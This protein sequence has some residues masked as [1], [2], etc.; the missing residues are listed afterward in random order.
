[1][2]GSIYEDLNEQQAAAVAH[3]EGPLM[4]LAGAGSGKTRVVTRR[5]ARLMMDGVRAH[6]ILALTFTNKAAGEMARRVEQ[7]GGDYVRVATFHSACA[8]FLRSEA[9]LIGYAPDY[10]IYDTQ[11]RDSLIKELMAEHHISTKEAKPSLIGN[12]ISK[13]KNA[14]MTPDD[15]LLGSSD[16]MR[17][18]ERL[19]SP[20]QERMKKASA[21]DFD[22]LLLNF[23]QILREHPAVAERYQE[24][25]PWVLVDEFQDT[26]RVQYD[27]LKLLCPSPSTGSAGNMCVVGDHDQSIYGFRGAEVRNILDFERDYEPC[28]VVRLEQNYRSTANILRAAE[29]VI[30]NN[31]MRKDKRLRTDAED[32]AS[33]LRLKATGATEEASTVVDR[34]QAMIEEGTSLEEVAV[35]YRAHWLSRGLEQALKDKGVPYEIVGGQTFFE[36]REIKDLLAYLRVLINPLDDVSMARVVNVPPR[37]LGKV[38][39]EKL[40]AAASAEG[41]SLREAVGEP[42]IH[43]VLSKKARAG[44]AELAQT[45][46]RAQAAAEQGAHAALREILE[47]TGYIR[48][49]TS[50]GDA[51]DSTRED[52]IAELVSDTVQFDAAPAA[53]EP[54]G[55][56]VGESPAAGLPGYLQHVALL[57]SADRSDDGPAV[58][59]MTVHAAKGLEFDHVFVCGLEEGTFPSMRTAD[60]PEGLEEERRLM[61]VALTR[62]RKTLMLSSARDRMVNGSMETMRPSRF[63]REIPEE[64]LENYAPS[65]RRYDLDDDGSH[66][67]GW[68]VTPD[69]EAL[70]GLQ[71]G[72]RVRHDLY[73]SGV[74]RRIA[75]RGMS[76]RA[77]V[78]F[79]DGIEREFVLEYAGLQLLEDMEF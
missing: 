72:V 16:V 49:A 48:H 9:H 4:V 35:F 22:D 47:G 39:L 21:M 65:W 10:S 24:R 68:S 42:S 2:H 61:Y 54:P 75:G 3:G 45:L 69:P 40:R 26:N 66:S 56:D 13:L 27:L 62:A 38:S 11:D 25:F 20:Y 78:R 53:P 18:V 71:K 29:T 34:V 60:D 64:L 67:T 50:Y 41:M 55:E 33:L 14:A 51:E 5:I 1:M 17:L 31:T 30:A 77:I 6:Q 74:V 44:L 46:D 7:L 36:R 52:N 32:G 70:E 19:W 58:R 28:T 37:G 59:M 57:T 79:D 76:A 73:G 12:W 63:L 23:L 43:G 15:G 8:R